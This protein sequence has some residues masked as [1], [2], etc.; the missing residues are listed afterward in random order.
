[1]KKE[2]LHGAGLTAFT[3]KKILDNY[4][5]HYVSNW[6]YRRYPFSS[7]V[8]NEA[9]QQELDPTTQSPEPIFFGIISP[10]YAEIVF[11]FVITGN[12][13]V[14]VL[15][16]SLLCKKNQSSNDEDDDDNNNDVSLTYFIL[17]IE[18]VVGVALPIS[19][20]L[21]SVIG[22]F[23]LFPILDILAG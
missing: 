5:C 15:V 7:I 22:V 2:I 13:V 8:I 14:V 11:I 10:L 17:F 19:V 4:R 12:A 1:M 9:A 21:I 20:L 23:I 3:M 16:L 18:S 6:I